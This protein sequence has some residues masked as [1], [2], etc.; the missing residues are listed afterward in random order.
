M[1]DGFAVHATLPA[2]DLDRARRWYEE[3]LGLKP[4]R[5]DEVGVWFEFAGSRL[6]LYQSGYAG[7][8]QSTSAE[9]LVEDIESVMSGLRARG[10]AFEEYDFPGL[11]TENGLATIGEHKTGWFRDSEGNILSLDEPPPGWADAS[12]ARMADEPTTV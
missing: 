7:T 4:V 2:S 3:K 11:K 1:L 9:F 5:E 8:A 6:L 12:D 10:V